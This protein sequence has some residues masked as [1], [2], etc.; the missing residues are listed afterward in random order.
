MGRKTQL[1]FIDLIDHGSPKVERNYT[2]NQNA[3]V[4]FCAFKT[5]AIK[6]FILTIK[7]MFGAK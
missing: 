6:I 7:G 4:L 5:S 3:M 1:S 2:E